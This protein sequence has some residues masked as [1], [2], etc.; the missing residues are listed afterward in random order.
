[1]YNLENLNIKDD[2]IKLV[3]NFSKACP[4]MLLEDKIWILYFD[5]G[6]L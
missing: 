5:E 4:F 6:I 3:P 2:E 1:M